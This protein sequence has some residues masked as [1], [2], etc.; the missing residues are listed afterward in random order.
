[1]SGRVGKIFVRCLAELG[2]FKSYVKQSWENLIHMSGRVGKKFQSCVAELVK[3]NISGRV[4]NTLYVWQ[5]WE[6]FSDMSGR[7]GKFQSDV[8]QSWENFINLCCRCL[9][10]STLQI[11]STF[12]EISSLR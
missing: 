2:K 9:M 11:R 12:P 8:W 6:N 4:G 5:S 7:V 10:I 1:M 3:F